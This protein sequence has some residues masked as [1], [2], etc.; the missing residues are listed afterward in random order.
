M[1]KVP[2]SEKAIFSVHC[3]NDLGMAVANSL[4]GIRAGCRQVECTINGIGERAGN[5]ALEE[6]VM[7]IKTRGDVLPYEVGIDASMLNRASKL[8][9]AATSFPVQYNKAIVGRNAFA[10]ESGIHQDGMLKHTQTYEIMTPESVG[11]SK[12]SL[13][14]GKHSGRNAF[15]AK[16][17][18]LGYQLGDNALEDA[19]NRFKT[20]ADRKKHVYDEDLE[21]LVDEEIATQQDRMKVVALTVIA[22]TGGPQKA[23]ITLDIDGKQHSFESTG[24]GPVDATFKAIKAIIPHEARLPLYQVSAV[25]EGTDAQAEVIVRLEDGDKT[26]TGRGSDTDTMV[27]SARAYVSALS[28][29]L[30]RGARRK[31]ETMLAS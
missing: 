9:A 5:A 28:K 15:R 11:V 21:A 25:T 2:G 1:E 16:L 26:V 24:D 6:L 20:L 8:V 22:G 23:N 19:F 17:K 29:L 12:T 30:A 18:E 14:M 4:A 7:A 13:V 3:H 31:P 27:A 10:H